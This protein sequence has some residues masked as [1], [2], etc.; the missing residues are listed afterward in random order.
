MT[1]EEHKEA[2]ALAALGEEIEPERRE[3]LEVH[4]AACGECRAELRALSDAAAMLA[5]SPPPVSPSPE[6]RSRVL[7]EIKTLPRERAA[8]TAT[9]DGSAPATSEAAVDVKAQADMQAAAGA[10]TTPSGEAATRVKTTPATAVPFE[11]PRREERAPVRRA[12]R[13]MLLF[14]YL[15]A[16]LAIAALA[17]SVVT[18]WQRNNQLRREV[19]RLS[20]QLEDARSQLTDTRSE[21]AR[22]R[23]EAEMLSAPDS[24]VAVL[25]GTEVASD[26]RARLVFNETTGE[27]VLVASKLPPPPAG[28]A[29]QLWYIAANQPPMPGPVFSTDPTGRGTLRERIP[30]EGRRAA[31]FAVTLE[32]E[33]GVTA[34][35][36]EMY[37]KGPAS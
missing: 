6:L 4:L 27:A 3:A 23:G 22:V 10:Q 31:I 28:K 34:P 26:A 8:T 24:H 16:S 35:T 11:R 36:G 1:H 33:G 30:P 32:P 14:G 15:A 17:V 7:A 2:L 37:L 19:A 20:S 18:L 29:Y 5:Y 21:M 12:R 13:P 25:T 9:F